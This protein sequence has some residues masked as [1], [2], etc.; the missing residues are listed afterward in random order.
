MGAA[1]LR[2]I[3]WGDPS[4]NGDF[5]KRRVFPLACANVATAEG[6]AFFSDR[7]LV[8]VGDRLLTVTSVVPATAQGDGLVIEDPAQALLRLIPTLKGSPLV[9][10]ADLD[11]SGLVELAKA[12]PGIAL[13]IGGDVKQPSQ[14]PV[15]VGACRVVHVANEGKTIGYWPWGGPACAFELISDQVPDHPDVRAVIHAYQEQLGAMNLA[16]DERVSGLTSLGGGDAGARYVGDQSCTPCH[17]NAAQVHGA[18][19]H[20]HAFAALERKGYHRDPDCLRCHV[21]GLGLPDG[22]RRNADA[23]RMRLTSMVSCESCHGRGS[24]HVTERTAGRPSSGSL[25]PVTPATCLVCHDREN[26][27]R[28]AFDSYWEKVRHGAR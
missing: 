18:S 25:T 21:T 28:F 8:Q 14:T 27:P 20:A 6:T 15:A 26:S 24:L 1:T 12:V 13:L 16:I 9:V 7:M 17:A 19:K 5:E 11:E 4:K 10:L 23:E 2:S 22:Y 3:I